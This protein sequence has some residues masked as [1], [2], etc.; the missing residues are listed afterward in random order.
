MKKYLFWTILLI[1]I[2]INIYFLSGK[3]IIV[4]YTYHQEQFQNQQQAQ[5][6]LTPFSAAGHLVWK[7]EKPVNIVEYLN[8]LA[9]E[10]SLMA[11]VQ[12]G[13]IYYPVLEPPKA[14]VMTPTNTPTNP[15]QNP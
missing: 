14:P 13:S 5:L 9:P 2:L 7:E 10:Q 3:G 1:S 6:I 4:S 8:H 15:T 12:N 11:K